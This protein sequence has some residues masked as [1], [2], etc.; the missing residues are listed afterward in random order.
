M[1]SMDTH[2]NYSF[3]LLSGRQSILNKTYPNLNWRKKYLAK[4]FG[5]FFVVDN[6]KDSN[7]NGKDGL[8]MLNYFFLKYKTVIAWII[9]IYSVILGIYTGILLS[10]FNARPLWNT[11]IL[12]PLFLTSGLST[13]AA[14]IFAS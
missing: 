5:I 10:A 6:R 11:S 13:G 2:G 14:V 7:W 3:I 4:F 1:G 9:L 8:R 12:G